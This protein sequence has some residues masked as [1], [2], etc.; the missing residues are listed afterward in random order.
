[1]HVAPGFRFAGLH[2]GIKPSKKDVA[3]VFSPTPCTAA[4]CLTINAAR[5]API[6]HAAARLPAERLHAVLVNAGV[7]NALTGQAG[8]DDVA[9][10]TQALEQE[11]GVPAGS[12]VMAST[13]VIGVRLPKEKILAALPTLKA[14]LGAVPEPAA[15]AIL[16]TDT[17]RKLAARQVQLGGKTITLSAIAKGSGMIAPSLA[18]MI[19]VLTT[20]C[21]ISAP[22]LQAAL[23]RAMGTSFNRLNVDNEMSTN[24]G[25]YALANGLA[26]NRAITDPGPDFEAF[27][28]ALES[29]C[30]ELARDIA[31]DGEGATRLLE[32]LVH[33][34]P[35]VAI[36]EDVAKS[37][38]GSTL[39]KAALFGADP[40]WGRILATVG[41]RIGAQQWAL[42]PAKARVELQGFVVYDEKPTGQ[43]LAQ[44]RLRMREP[45]VKVVVDLRGGS[46]EANAW[47]CDL[48]YDYV[49]L[50]ADYTSML[51]SGSDG[52]VQ[53]DDRLAN[54]SP[55]FKVGLLTQA[56]GYIARFAGTRCVLKV[57][58]SLLEKDSL[59]QAF[60]DDVNRLRSVGLQ[61]IVVHGEAGDL[62]ADAAHREVLVN[63]ATNAGLVARLNRLGGAAVGL[64][65]QDGGFLR[66]RAGGPVIQGLELGE[67]VQVNTALLEALMGQ[68]YVPVI[69]PV[70]MAENTTVPVDADQLAAHVAAALKANKL[71]YL[72]G[73]MGLP[74]GDE[75]VPQLTSTE[76]QGLLAVGTLRSSLAGKSAGALHALS[77]GVARVHIIDGRVPHTLIAELFTDEGVGTL[78]THG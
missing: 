66:A 58:R 5:A 19:V 31:A 47:G 2:A 26:K 25:V 45:F 62:N 27:A 3:L 68:G 76:L 54:F 41:A 21:A 16:T 32:V 69:A 7:A 29:L 11:L 42:D 22:M 65:G 40:N 36:A 78:V 34:A 53:K 17:R 46:H 48:S 51:R 72:T 13:G 28:E 43:D 60:C 20:D 61:P 12:T 56:L 24:D 14:T 52:S 59:V 44:L 37:V 9:V 30:R 73:S 67:V 23:T 35:S 75:V 64:S 33:G 4:A 18:T 74:R 71:V 57:G 1:M 6:T 8:L 77:Q 39:V 10:I 50:N 55:A 15:D 49:K 70:G 63:G 38:A